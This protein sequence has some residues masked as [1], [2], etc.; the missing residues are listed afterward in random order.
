M[1][2]IPLK[3][4]R[5]I[6]LK[7]VGYSVVSGVEIVSSHIRDLDLQEAARINPHIFRTKYDVE[8]NYVLLYIDP[9]VPEGETKMTDFVFVTQAESY[10]NE[11]SG[12]LAEFYRLIAGDH[13]F[14]YAFS[15]AL[16]APDRARLRVGGFGRDLEEECEAD[17][18]KI[19]ERIHHLET[20]HEHWPADHPIWKA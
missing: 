8:K 5:T 20:T 17:G 2:E 13:P 4:E 19:L 18:P 9:C 7:D 10:L 12:D 11:N 15:R 14:G 3:F 1:R 16:S 6:G